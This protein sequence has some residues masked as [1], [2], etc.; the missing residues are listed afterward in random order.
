MLR[1]QH[2]EFANSLGWHVI[3]YEKF[4]RFDPITTFMNRALIPIGVVAALFMLFLAYW[5]STIRLLIIVFEFLIF[6]AVQLM[7]AERVGWLAELP[8][9]KM[10]LIGFF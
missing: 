5:S 7:P 3:S 10:P 9:E 8:V 2:A 6:L 4:P 1:T